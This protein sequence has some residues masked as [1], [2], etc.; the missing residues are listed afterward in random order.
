MYET[1]NTW[2]HAEGVL[3]AICQSWWCTWDYLR[4]IWCY[5]S[6]MVVDMGLSK[7][8]LVLSV[9]HGGGNGIF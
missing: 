8:D 4:V 2:S 3:G 1:Q 6:I 7:G 9:N 5:L